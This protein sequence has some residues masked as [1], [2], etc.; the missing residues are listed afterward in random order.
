MENEFDVIIIGTGL[1]HS[2]SAA[3][4]AKAGLKVAHVDPNP[5]YGGDE[6]ALTLDEIVAWAEHHASSDS[7]D[8]VQRC[9]TYTTEYCSAL[10]VSHPKQYTISLSPSVIPAIGPF[11]TSVIASGISRYCSFKLLGP[12][13]IY[14]GGQF[15]NVPR[16][17]EDVFRDQKIPLIEKRRLMRFLMFVAGD[18]ES[19]PEFQGKEDTPF[20]EF[21]RQTFFLSEDISQSIVFALAYCSHADEPTASALSRVRSC[22]QSTGRYGPSPFVVSY[23][24]G[25][26]DLA[27][28]FCRAAAVNGSVYILGRRIANIVYRGSSSEATGGSRRYAVE[29]DNFPEPLYASCLLSSQCHVPD[30]LR[31]LSA[32]ISSEPSDAYSR[33]RAVARG[34]VILDNP[35]LPPREDS[36]EPEATQSD[37]FIMVFPPGSVGGGSDVSAVHVLT[38]G[39]GTMCAPPGK[40]IVYLSMPLLDQERGAKALLEPYLIAILSSVSP[41]PNIL[42]QTFYT[43]HFP[44]ETER[45]VLM[46][47]EDDI[48]YWTVPVLPADMSHAVDYAAQIAEKA[49]WQVTLSIRGPDASLEVSN[50][51]WV[52]A[53]SNVDEDSD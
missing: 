36:E 34:I 23:Y 44:T 47:S 17:K 15:K 28:A 10:N 40:C 5:Y 38:A 24:G 16:G 25:S 53:V 35:L 39:P 33:I 11:I 31:H 27:Q 2:M 48:T 19:S 22:L 51:F 18:Y 20:Q 41:P 45:D 9:P 30:H 50:G 4:L 13:S 7:V 12:V 46:G 52:D 29:L 21:L 8:Q 37:S 3:A 1:T 32:P 43:Q 42:F 6:A 14:N 26:G 49:F